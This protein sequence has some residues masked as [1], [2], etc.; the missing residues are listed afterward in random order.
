VSPVRTRALLVLLLAAPT[1]GTVAARAQST[2]PNQSTQTYPADQVAAGQTAFAARCGFC[3][4]RDATGGQA[5]PDLTESALVAADVRGDRIAGVVRSG[6]PEKG[7]PP[8]NVPDQELAAIV[9][10]V[11]T[12]K[13]RL[14]A[15][16]GRRRRVADEDLLSGGADPE[17]GRRYFTSSG[18]ANCHSTT[19]DLAGVG[20][21]FRGLALMQQLLYPRRTTTT[22]PGAPAPVVKP[23]PTRVTV[24]LPSGAVV[25]GGLAYRDEFTIALTDDAGWYR[26]W[27][28]HQVKFTLTDPLQ[29]H[30]DQLGKY[31]EADM[32]NVYAYLLTLR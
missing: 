18:C 12:Q 13:S 28:T 16:P 5:G 21:R 24:T 2:Q 19:G 1:A 11:H 23:V 9:A 32:H 14:D 6:R 17:A 4:G 30:V 7:M 31:T 29:A 10:F 22:L 26:S 8:L 20:T 25:T 27:P 3:H 15:Q